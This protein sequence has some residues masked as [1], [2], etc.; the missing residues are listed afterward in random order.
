MVYSIHLPTYVTYLFHA[1]TLPMFNSYIWRNFTFL[2]SPH[3]CYSEYGKII[4]IL[5][6][7]LQFICKARKYLGISFFIL[8]LLFFVSYSSSM[9]RIFF[10]KWH[11]SDF[12]LYFNNFHIFLSLENY[13]LLTNNNSYIF[14]DPFFPVIEVLK[15]DFENY[16]R[17]C[18][19]RSSLIN[20]F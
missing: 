5:F 6:N 8:I 7:N 1:C 19:K 4:P 14:E 3:Q 12:F 2:K 17:P 15:Q 13:V 10:C 9:T 18:K 20:I 11:L 16:D